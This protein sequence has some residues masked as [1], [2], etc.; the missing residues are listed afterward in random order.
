MLEVFAS[1]DKLV[2]CISISVE[3][4]SRS[5]RTVQDQSDFIFEVLKKLIITNIRAN[6][7]FGEQGRIAGVLHI[8][9]EEKKPIKLTSR[10]VEN[11]EGS[12]LSNSGIKRETHELITISDDA[13]SDSENV[14][15]KIIADNHPG[16]C[17]R[18]RTKRLR[19][20]GISAGTNSTSVRTALDFNYRH[21]DA[22]FN[23]EVDLHSFSYNEAGELANELEAASSD[24]QTSSEP[25]NSFQ[26]S[27][28]LPTTLKHQESS[29][30]KSL[31]SG[32]TCLDCDKVYCSIDE[33][34]KHLISYHLP[35]IESK[36]PEI[37]IQQNENCY[38]CKLCKQNFLQKCKLMIHIF[39]NHLIS[40]RTNIHCPV[41]GKEGS[42]SV[43]I[44]HLNHLHLFR[45]KCHVCK[46]YVKRGDD[47][48]K[49][50]IDEHS[51][52]IKGCR[53]DFI[54]REMRSAIAFFRKNKLP[55]KVMD[56]VDQSPS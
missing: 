40:K 30:Y 13:D 22:T 39:Q 51:E 19:Q 9:L 8:M 34:S 42:T 35:H 14:V 29:V 37:F 54:A 6:Y 11:F 4:A 44:T 53:D 50:F 5:N 56:T 25:R 1:D 3:N 46:Q 36:N 31:V 17:T 12:L 10:F 33:F 45:K 27:E 15:R 52:K 7:S 47:Y 26:D 24:S 21:L 43:I 32:L 55:D 41:C 38:S 49:H 2:D 20:S 16:T 48:V 18:S 28:W 23:D